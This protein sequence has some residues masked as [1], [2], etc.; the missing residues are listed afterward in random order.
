MWKWRIAVGLV[1]A[2]L[3]LAYWR[4]PLLR[5]ELMTAVNRYDAVPRPPAPENTSTS[6]L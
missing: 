1:V 5:R 6:R 2:G 4:L 3:A